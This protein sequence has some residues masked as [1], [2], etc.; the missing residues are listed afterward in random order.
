MK[1]TSSERSLR[2]TAR[3]ATGSFGGPHT[4]SPTIRI[5]PNPSRVTCMSPPMANVPD[6]VAVTV[7]TARYLSVAQQPTQHARGA[8][9]VRQAERAVGLLA[10]VVDEHPHQRMRARP[11]EQA[12]HE[13]GIVAAPHR[14]LAEHE[15]LAKALD[16]R[17]EALE[18]G[19]VGEL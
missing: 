10:L 19:E 17:V 4:P 12:R 14:P 11:G 8:R 5:A 18:P 9:V 3:T 15:R 16:A 1:S 2:R 6:A 13:A 7:M